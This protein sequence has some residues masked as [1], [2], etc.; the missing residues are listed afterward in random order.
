[1][2]FAT[3]KSFSV[4]KSWL[5]NWDNQLKFEE[6]ADTIVVSA[7][8]G[9][10]SSMFR[11]PIH[12][13][14]QSWSGRSTVRAAG[15]L[16]MPNAVQAEVDLVTGLTEMWHGRHRRPR[17]AAEPKRSTQ[18]FPGDHDVKVTPAVLRKY[19]GIPNAEKNKSPKNLQGIAAFN[20]YYCDEALTQ[21]TTKNKLDTP[22]VIT[23][24]VD[25]RHA[26]KPC[27]Q[28]E[29]DLDMQ[30]VTAIGAGTKTLFHNQNDDWVLQFTEDAAKLS[31]LPHVFSMSYGWAELR[32]CDI[33]FTACDKLGYDASQ[34]VKRTNT[35]FQK[36]ATLGVS[37]IVSD[38]D[39][40]AQ[41]N[42][43]DGSDPIDPKRWCGGSEY[44]CYPKTKS[45]C[46]EILLTNHSLH[47]PKSCP[48]PVGSLGELCNF[49][50]LGDFYQD[51]A[52]YKALKDAN[53]DCKLQIFYDGSYGVHLYSECG[54]SELSPLEH[55][56][57]ISEPYKFNKSARVFFADF[58][59]G[60]PYVTSIGAT[61]FKSTDGVKIDAE[62]TASI[63]D[64]AII[65]TGGG[66][67]AVAAQP[68]YQ[69]EAVEG[70]ANNAPEDA[71]PPAYMYDTTKRGYPDVT[72]NGHNYQVFYPSKDKAITCPCKEG[73]VDGTSASAPAFAGLVSLL[74]GH[75]LG[76][77]KTALGFLN[78][79]LYKMSAEAPDAYTDITYGDNKCTRNF[80][81]IYGYNATKG[82]D[83]VAGLGS[84]NY[85]AMKKYVLAQKRVGAT[86]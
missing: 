59:T 52:I 57:V 70:W 86:P 38:G 77:G 78:P 2:V 76:A 36:L 32:Q 68:K 6:T 10:V 79:L 21:F 54:C 80:C 84:I 63:V 49:L 25:C 12:N 71:K 15:S 50:Y 18:R 39:D 61:A 60:S 1:M 35:G 20:D 28:V 62:H 42:S 23:Q 9:T 22:D 5:M 43:P 24:G 58:P 16:S 81:M 66:F 69:K 85:P 56:G 65:T 11:C 19:Y 4:V 8:A 48:W 13:Y 40:G 14:T 74:N 37:I 30:Y 83:P 33:A 7:P 3:P 53:P 75:L 73:G 29:S 34:Y 72:L 44:A 26:S 17:V 47:P 67:S 82:W 27:D 46:A 41:S 55:K 51:E 64:G 45:K 31:P